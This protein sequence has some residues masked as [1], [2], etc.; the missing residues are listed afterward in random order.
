VIRT[1]TRRYRIDTFPNKVLQ[2][3]WNDQGRVLIEN[4]YAYVSLPVSSFFVR[5]TNYFQK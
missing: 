3:V 1:G 5:L 4:T 2:G